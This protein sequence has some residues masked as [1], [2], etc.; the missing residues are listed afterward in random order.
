MC[1]SFHVIYFLYTKELKP[2]PQSR[3][4]LFAPFSGSCLLSC[5]KQYFNQVSVLILNIFLNQ[6]ATVLNWKCFQH[7]ITPKVL[8]SIHLLSASSIWSTHKTHSLQHVCTLPH[9][10]LF[11]FSIIKT[12]SYFPD[13]KASG[14]LFYVTCNTNLQW[15]TRL[16]FH[17][18]SQ[19][20][21]H[22][23]K[24]ILM[25]FMMLCLSE[26][27]R[28]LCTFMQLTE[29]IK[30]RHLYCSCPCFS[31]QQSCLGYFHPVLLLKEEKYFYHYENWKRLK[32]SWSVP[33]QGSRPRNV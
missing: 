28:S 17:T 22:L 29:V 21:F 30:G 15:T 4:I 8:S 11:V 10:L 5:C 16:H 3:R 31:I 24:N 18:L 26:C 13:P 6:V 25:I 2:V 32:F 33:G 27:H 19:G 23:S 12:I 14:Y 9:N 20:D 1:E 7:L